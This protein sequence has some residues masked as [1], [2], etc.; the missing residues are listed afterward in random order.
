MFPFQTF[1]WKEH[2][3][4][5]D[6]RMILPVTCTSMKFYLLCIYF[7][8]TWFHG[9][10]RVL[11]NYRGSWLSMCFSQMTTRFSGPGLDL[12]I[13]CSLREG[14]WAGLLH[15][16]ICDNIRILIVLQ[17]LLPWAVYQEQYSINLQTNSLKKD[18][19]SIEC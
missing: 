2:V 13:Y 12:W 4:L 3:C 9:E 5:H 15:S 14:P 7:S 1:L 19:S 8:I 10:R 11:T 18:V 16:T 17:F 6:P